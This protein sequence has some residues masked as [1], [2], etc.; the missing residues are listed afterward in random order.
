MNRWEVLKEMY[1]LTIYNLSCYSEDYLMTKPKIDF[2]EQWNKELEKSKIIEDMIT[3]E[4][5]S[6]FQTYTSMYNLRNATE[7]ISNMELAYLENRDKGI[8]CYLRTEIGEKEE[9]DYYLVLT[10]HKKDDF[11]DEYEN[12]YTRDV[13]KESFKDRETLKNEM[14]SALDTFEKFVEADKLYSKYY[15]DKE[16]EGFE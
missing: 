8:S 14:Q 12:I 2:E 1:D 4:E 3:E 16:T 10:L 6:N 15:D 13:N 7:I 9:P 5:N 11:D